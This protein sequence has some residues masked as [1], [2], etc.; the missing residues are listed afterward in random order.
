MTRGGEFPHTHGSN[1]GQSLSNGPV[2]LSKV[3]GWE[4]AMI[5][6]FSCWDFME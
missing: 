5:R 2:G 3:L 6:P 1:S 4:Q